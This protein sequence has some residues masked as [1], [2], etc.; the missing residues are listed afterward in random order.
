MRIR[1]V[2]HT[3]NQQLQQF[4]VHCSS[5]VVQKHKGVECTKRKYKASNK[6]EYTTLKERTQG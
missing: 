2:E 4:I 5:P 1:N 3:V 6:P